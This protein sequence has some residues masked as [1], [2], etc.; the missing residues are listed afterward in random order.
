MQTS[1]LEYLQ[2]SVAKF[3]DKIAFEDEKRALSFQEIDKEARIISNEIIVRLGLMN[4]Q[5]ILIFLSKSVSVI[6]SMFGVLYSG[7]FY[8]PTNPSFPK[9]KILDIIEVLQPKIV[10]SDDKNIEKLIQYGVEQ[11]K[12]INLNRLDFSFTN[13][14]I[15]EDSTIDTDLAYV[16]FT[17]GST[18]KPKGVS[19]SHRS[20]IEFVD[21]ACETL[22]IDEQTVFGNQAA[23]YFDISGQ[24]IYATLKK[25]ARLVVIPEKLFAFPVRLAEFIEQNNINFLSWV[26]SAY[27]NLSKAL[28]IYTLSKIKALV[29]SGEI[30]PVKYLNYLKSK[31]PN[32]QFI[33]NA[34]G[35]T[36]ATIFSTYFVLNREFGDD[37][38]LPLGKGLENKRV[39]LLD[40]ENK[41]ISISNVI[42]EL[43]IA[44]NSLSL[45]YYR[46]LEKTQEVFVQN[47]LHSA[48]RDIIYRT[49]DLASYNEQGELIFHGRIDNQIKHF[50]Y[51]IELGEIEAAALSLAYITN[52]VCFYNEKEKEIVLVYCTNKK[53][54]N[55]LDFMYDL[56][57]F[58]PKYMVPSK[59]YKLMD[60]PLNANGKIDRIKIK[61]YFFKDDD[62]R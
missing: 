31:M 56:E 3:P 60:F 15:N 20:L 61:N 10:I 54:L 51:R 22:P 12:I 30:M 45:G 35:P 33:C 62:E 14:L 16:F 13:P 52:C 37:E 42:G 1:I 55:E 25:S 41:Q 27:I 7:N 29:F 6:S 50:G 9:H 2:H 36:E 28:N 18:G 11:E 4:N 44:G 23:F 21:W 17:S 32:L 47:P 59:Y 24:D 34:Y 8:T 46:N 53:E 39:F 26:P 57:E 19:V 49:G 48:Y 40:T 5:P 58:L 43:C 38:M